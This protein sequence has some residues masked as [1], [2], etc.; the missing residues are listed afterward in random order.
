MIPVVLASCTIKKESTKLIVGK[1]TEAGENGISIFTVNPAEGTLNLLSEADAGPNPSYFCISQKRNLIYAANEVMDFMGGTG[2]GVTTLRYNVQSDT[3]IK[4]DEIAVPNGSPCFISLSPDEAFLFLANYTGGSVTVIK[5]DKEGIP[6]T[7]TDSI[8]FDTTGEHTS[9]PHMISFD[10]AGKRVYL[11]DLGLNQIS[12]YTFDSA[13]G[14]L[15]AI[16]NG[17]IKLTKGSGPRHFA[18][19]SAGSNMYVINELNSTITVFKVS[20]DGRL[21]S[22]QSV[23]TLAEDFKGESYCADI[24]FGKNGDFLYGSNRG[25]NSIVTFKIGS[26]GLLTLVGRTSCGGNW[27]R[28]FTIDETGAYLLVGNQKSGS[29][30]VLRIDEKSGIPVETKNQIN[31]SAPACLRFWN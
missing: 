20:P 5:L 30:T 29:I 16:Q 27:P 4:V 31:V 3:L 18:F 9:H 1:Y 17:I 23:K 15:E 19:N 8:L 10:P 12:V 13:S 22:I 28:N 21:D 11:T 14:K 7:I 6:A 25:E 24:H 26:D 2:G